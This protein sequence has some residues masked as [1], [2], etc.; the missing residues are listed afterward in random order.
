MKVVLLFIGL[1]ILFQGCSKDDLSEAKLFRVYGDGQ[2]QSEYLYNSNGL[3][4]TQTS[5][6]AGRKSGEV[7]CYYD[8][9]NKLVKK[10]TTLDFSSST[11][12]PQWSYSYTEYSY[13]AD[14]RISE[15]KT[16]L[17]QNNIYVLVSKTKPVYDANRRLVSKTLL[18]PADVPARLTKYQ[19]SSGNISVQEEYQYNGAIPELQRKMS[20]DDFD[21]KINPY[22]D[23][24]ASVPP[25]SINRNNV[26]KITATDYINNPGT[27]MTSV[28]N[29]IYNEYTR[30]GLPLK[31]TE[32][33]ASFVYEYK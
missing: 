17:R 8:A 22:K 31:V 27:P 19:Y 2:L 6:F 10:E 29:S 28:N 14:G 20:Y 3:L 21:T 30:N 5:Y 7:I 15:E 16:Y 1:S 4:S 11:T 33:G 32:N 24:G 9:G 13:S 12:S 23:L 26:L 25:Y 18:T